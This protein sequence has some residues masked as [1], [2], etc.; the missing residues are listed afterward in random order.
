MKNITTADCK[1]FIVEY[2]NK[3]NNETQNK[4]SDWK[5]IKKYQNTH[6]EVIREFQHKNG[7]IFHVAE[8]NGVLQ[9]VGY[10]PEI[11]LTCEDEQ[12]FKSKLI[13]LL[14]TTDPEEMYQNGYPYNIWPDHDTLQNYFSQFEM[15]YENVGGYLPGCGIHKLDCGKYVFMYAHGGD[16]EFPIYDILFWDHEYDT[17]CGYVPKAGNFYDFKEKRAFGNI[18]TEDE[19]KI[20]K[21]QYKHIINKLPSTIPSKDLDLAITI[22]SDY[23]TDNGILSMVLDDTNQYV[24]NYFNTPRAYDNNTYN[25]SF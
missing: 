21:S 9:R 19:I 8:D 16:W 12:T 23:L 17:W 18:D 20:I 1:K 2:L 10:T 24:A 15:D 22:I 14:A 7:N 4:E 11:K 13:E 6:G 5:R 25:P 3:V